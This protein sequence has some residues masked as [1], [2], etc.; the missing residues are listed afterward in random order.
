EFCVISN[1]E[2]ATPPAFDA[3]PGANNILALWN[4]SMA[5][6]V[7][8]ILAPSLTQIHPFFSNVT[9]ASLSSSFW[10]AHGRA[11]SHTTSQGVFPLWYS[12]LGYLFRYSLI[13]PLFS[14]FRCMTNFNF[15]A[16]IPS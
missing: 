1:P 15:S 13:R 2:V 4:A 16:S 5:P 11:T 12:A 7:D 6:L 10:V 8:G 3:L 14:F 9:A